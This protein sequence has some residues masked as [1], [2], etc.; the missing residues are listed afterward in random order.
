MAFQRVA[1]ADEVPVGGVVFANLSEPVCVVRVDEDTVKAV[2]DVCSHEEYPLHEG[3]VEDN[4][5]EC[6]LHGSMFNLDTGDPDALP[7][8]DAIPV[9]A[10]QVA[11]GAIWVDLDDKLNSAPEP[12]H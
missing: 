9:Y 6:A 4:D 2:H 8:V 5:I 10:A 11:D 3:F 1:G 7:A 12:R